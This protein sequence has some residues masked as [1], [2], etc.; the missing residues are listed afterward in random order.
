MTERR[1]R[2]GTEKLSPRDR[3]I[4]ELTLQ[5]HTW[6]DET[7]WLNFSDVAEMVEE[8]ARK[9]GVTLTVEDVK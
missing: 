2:Y 7:V 5:L 4:R 6:Q 9:A 8:A 3:F 1:A